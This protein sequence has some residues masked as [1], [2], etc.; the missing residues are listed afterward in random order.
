MNYRVTPFASAIAVALS[1]FVVQQA[2][3]QTTLN[4]VVVKTG[5]I[6]DAAASVEI[7]STE[8]AAQ[9][10]VTRDTASLLRD[11]PGVHLYGAGGVSSLPVI[12]GL[13]DDRLRITIDGMDFIS[14]CANHMNPPLSY[15]D[16]GNVAKIRVYAGISPVSV[17]GDSIGG[18]IVAE[19]AAPQFAA[20]GQRSLIKG[21]V[22]SFYRSNNNAFGGNLS[23]TLAN[24]FF[25]IN[26]SGAITTADNYKAGG[27]FKTTTATGRPGH[28]LPLDE[29]GSTAYKSL[30]HTLGLALRADNHLLEAKFGYQ[31]VPYQFYPNQRMDMLDNEQK[32]I[33]ARYLGEYNWGTLDGRV[34]Y[35]AVDHYMNFSD[36]KQLVYG[37]ALNGMPMSSRGRTLGLNLKGDVYLT[38]DDLLRVGALYQHY[39]LRDWWPPSGTGAMSPLNF[40]N[41]N[42]G[43]RDRLGFFAEWERHFNP[44]W[45]T[46]LGARY[47]HLETDA[48]N[49]HGYGNMMGNQIPD[50]AAFN[51]R[52]HKRNDNNVDLTAL[53]RYTP[54]NMVDLELGLARK[55]RTPNLYERYTWSTWSMAAIMNNFVGDGNGYVGNMDL[56]PEKAYTASL[57]IDLHAADREWEIKATPYFT[58]VNNYVD[59][60]RIPAVTT[61]NQFVVLQY[62]NHSAHLY[63]VDLS[64]RTVLVKTSLGEFGLRGLMNYTRGENKKTG[65]DLY[66]IMPLNGKLTLTHQYSNWSN[67]IELVGATRKND[68]SSVRNEIHTKGYFLTNLRTSYTWKNVRVDLGVEN[69]FDRLYYLPLGGAYTGQGMT[70]GINGIPYGIAVPGMGRSVYAGLNIKF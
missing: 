63:G 69:L 23:A 48:D 70:M 5:K 12:H 15:L 66:N 54:G 37:T 7:G 26:Y 29:V 1:S 60:I 68:V 34:Y 40:Q 49:V 39:T 13:A 31:N 46:L 19:T 25:S 4:E 28:T 35:E 8:I 17:G 45:T 3:A 22:G 43:K 6:R 42:H 64:G 55:V 18:T 14:S 50:S 10:A 33:N 61:N 59:A 47:E 32:R 9:H 56:K 38:D 41:I 30:T 67:A 16:P 11:V 20:P 65:D 2:L 24:E 51:A 53:A 36:D 58:Y 21:E 27:N 52:G 44:Q 57:T 62:A